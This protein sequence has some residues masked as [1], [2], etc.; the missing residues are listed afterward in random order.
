M[1]PLQGR[2][3]HVLRRAQRVNA[4]RDAE[5]TANAEAKEKL[6]AEAE[7]IDVSDPKA[8]QAA[9]RAIG[10]KWDAIGKVPRDRVTELERGCGR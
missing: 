3:G 6:L 1:G 5:F 2:P 8:A 4:E 7:R 10:D 9:L